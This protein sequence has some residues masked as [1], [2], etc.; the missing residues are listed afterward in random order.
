M[1]RKRC[2]LADDTVD[3]EFSVEGYLDDISIKN[4]SIDGNDYTYTLEPHGNLG[5]VKGLMLVELVLFDTEKF[6]Q[7]NTHRVKI[8]EDL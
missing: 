6:L 3:I 2:F 4:L 7:I 8:E 5:E 1:I